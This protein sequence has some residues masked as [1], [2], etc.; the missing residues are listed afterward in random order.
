[1]NKTWAKWFQ[2][3]L[4]EAGYRD[5]DSLVVGVS[6][7]PDSLA[8]FHRLRNFFDQD[9]LHVAHLDHSIRP[10]STNEAE[11]IADLSSSWVIPFSIKKVD[12]PDLARQRG[13]SLEEAARNARYN[14]FADIAQ[15]VGA[16]IVLVGHNSDDQA[17]TVLLHLLRGSGLRGLR[18]MLP[19]SPLPG[20]P[21]MKLLRPLLILSRAEIDAYCRKHSLNPLQDESNSDPAYL[22]NRVRHKLLPELSI[23]NPQIKNQ[24][25]QLAEIAS[26]EDDLVTMIFEDTWPRLVSQIGDGWISLDRNRFRDLPLA[27][28][29]RTLRHAVE[30]LLTGVADLSFKTVEQALELAC[31]QE[32]GTETM[33]LGG[34]TMLVDYEI[35]FFAQESADVPLDLP[36]MLLEE[37]SDKTLPL[38]IPGKV[39]LANGWVLTAELIEQEA[40]ENYLQLDQWTAVID[41]PQEDWLYVRPRKSGERMQPLGM[42]GHSS[43]VQDIMVN[44]KI[45]ARLREKWP[46]VAKDEHVVWLTGH[47][48]DHRA[49]ITDNSR[50]IV[51][52]NCV[53][54][55]IN[56]D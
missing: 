14:F 29:R 19:L 43:S 54:K 37:F 52:L 15:K 7:G 56:S 12:V 47:I 22:R 4:N 26:A 3:L 8:L 33:L 10:S 9:V 18:G 16:R 48:I 46:L 39:L 55:V 34:L 1:M 41:L 25:L 13:W 45:A 49:R 20:S 51:K 24:L 5:G 32:S 17:E 11:F 2:A 30:A 28:Q 40:V 6:G 35:L 53:Q 38:Q 21:N 23:Y 27:I 36:Q 50:R 31:R 42:S 44:R